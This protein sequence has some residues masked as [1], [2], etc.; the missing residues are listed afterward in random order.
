MPYSQ[1]TLAQLRTLLRAR[2]DNDAGFW[3][4]S[5]LTQALN[6]SLSVFQLATGRWRQRYIVTS[7]ANRVFYSIPDLPQLQSGG[8]C[9]VIA[10]IRV[11]FNSGQPLGWTN[12]ADLDLAYPGWQTQTTTT[13]GA[14]TTP[15]M[16]G[17]IGTNIFFM[18]PAD[19]AGN[20]SLQMDVLTNA[21]QLVDDADF[22]NL[23][24]TET[25]GLL[26]YSEH[27]IAMKRGGIFFA[28]TLPLLKS[29]YQLLADRNSYLLNLAIFRQAVGADY[30]RNYSPRRQSERSGRPVGVSLR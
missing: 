8:L 16:C 25:V 15:Q 5:E 19:A 11:S 3:A 13:A 26:D 17:M 2:L 30:A 14:P 4:D 1:I 6:E 18:W 12:F 29:F 27:R 9:Q 7:V 22:V 10:P 20:N 21:P 24:A 23:D 28:R